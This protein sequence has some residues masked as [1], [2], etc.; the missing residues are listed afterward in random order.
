MLVSL[1]CSVAEG[2]AAVY[3][4]MID[5]LSTVNAGD[6]YTLDVYLTE[7]IAIGEVTVLG[8]SSLGVIDAN[9]QVRIVSGGSLI[10]KVTGNPAFDSY[11][12]DVT[13]APWILNQSDIIVADGTPFG[14]SINTGLY[15]LKLGAITGTGSLNSETTYFEIIDPNGSDP[16]FASMV[17]GDGTVLDPSVFPSVPFALT[18][19]GSGS[20]V[21][22]EPVSILVWSFGAIAAVVTRRRV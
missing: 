6:S 15:R 22:P 5:G 20:S 13:Q 2:H 21:V 12:G 3:S 11:G 1:L 7:Q 19:T 9:F 14:E 4:I 10:S 16:L 8:D 18:T 17:L